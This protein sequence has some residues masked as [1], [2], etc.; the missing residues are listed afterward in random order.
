MEIKTKPVTT[1]IRFKD[2]DLLASSVS[3]IKIKPYIWGIVLG[4]ITI[5]LISIGCWNYFN[6][7]VSSPLKEDHDD[8]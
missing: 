3:S 5:S 2:V 7:A 8:T 4:I 6:T 1:E